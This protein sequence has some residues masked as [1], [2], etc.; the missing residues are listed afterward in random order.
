ME[1]KTTL[2][3]RKTNKDKEEEKKET[4]GPYRNIEESKKH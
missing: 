2:K 3:R 4:F 1:K